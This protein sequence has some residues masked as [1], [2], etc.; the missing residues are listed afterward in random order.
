MV[1]DILIA[2]IGIIVGFCVGTVIMAKYSGTAHK[3]YRIKSGAYDGFF[4]VNT[5]DPDKDVFTLELTCAV[6]SIPEKDELIFKV[7]NV[8]S[9]EKPSL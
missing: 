3:L 6:G 4:K 8:S 9:Q 1:V 2:I 5:S 7:E